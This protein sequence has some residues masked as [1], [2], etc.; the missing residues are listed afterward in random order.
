MQCSQAEIEP[1]SV[2]EKCIC[3]FLN[4]KNSK[5]F[6]SGKQS[7]KNAASHFCQFYQHGVNSINTAESVE[8]PGFNSITTE[9]FATP[10]P[11]SPFSSC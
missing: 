1:L 10:E 9:P 11:P 2:A 5:N 4:S 8:L 3:L 6:K 7:E